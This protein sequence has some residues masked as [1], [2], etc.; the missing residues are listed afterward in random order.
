M[1]T[2]Y[3]LLGRAA[4]VTPGASQTKSK[5]PGR[6]GPD[7]LPDGRAETFP[8]FADGGSGAHLVSADGRRYLDCFGANAA[9]PLGYAHPLVTARVMAALMSGPLL[10]LPHVWE[11]P[12]SELFLGVCAPWADQVR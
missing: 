1:L 4:R 5:A 3:E 9:I 12:V 6:L 10:S 11:A 7:A 2:A 8:L